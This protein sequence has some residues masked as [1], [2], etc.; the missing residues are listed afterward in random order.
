M[1][2]YISQIEHIVLSHAYYKAYEP[3]YRRN[4]RKRE[5]IEAQAII[6]HFSK[7]YFKLSSGDLG[8]Y[9]RGKTHSAILHSLRNFDDWYEVDPTFKQRVDEIAPFIEAFYNEW[10]KLFKLCDE[11]YGDKK[12]FTRMELLNFGKICTLL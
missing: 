3:L 4:A 2:E 12:N 5:A 11:I 1:T 7:A 9:V 6:L 8:K 10:C